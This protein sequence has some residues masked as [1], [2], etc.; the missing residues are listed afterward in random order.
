M[1]S[2][3][4]PCSPSQFQDI[5]AALPQEG[6]VITGQRIAGGGCEA[7]TVT[8][9]GTVMSYSF[10]GTTLTVTGVSKT[11]WWPTWDQI[12]NMLQ[13]HMEALT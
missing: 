12:F 3:S 1:P 9:G 5:L 4:I 13:T 2:R 6:C 7:G 10:D 8:N 11:A